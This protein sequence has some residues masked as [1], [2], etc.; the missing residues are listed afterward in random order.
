MLSQLSVCAA[1]VD[2]VCKILLTAYTTLLVIGMH[3]G[4]AVFKVKRRV[5]IDIDIGLAALHDYDNGVHST[6]LHCYDRHTQAAEPS[7]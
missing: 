6:A 7:I 1:V 5:N 4:A 3:H 2:C